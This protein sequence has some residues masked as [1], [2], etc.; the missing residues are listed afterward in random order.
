MNNKFAICI[1]TYNRADLL[2]PAL[3]YYLTDFPT[4][5]IYVL[6]NSDDFGLHTKDTF[7]KLCFQLRLPVTNIIFLHEEVNIGV[8][9]SW[10]KLVNMAFDT[11]HSHVLMLNDD[12]YLG[13]KEHSFTNILLH[14][15]SNNFDVEFM[16][17]KELDFSSFLISKNLYKKIG[18]FDE[19]YYPAYYEDADYK[20][21]MASKGLFVNNFN[22]YLMDCMVI[23]KSSSLQKEP[24][25]LDG[26]KEK[27]KARFLEKWGQYSEEFK[28][29]KISV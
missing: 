11:G 19:A 27:N 29:L 2:I 21:R 12:V 26:Y 22:Y 25:L 10:N 5:K 23:N 1:P 3:L 6:V 9:A 15:Q 8:A 4:T 16:T 14:F 7:I 20:M 18:A 24:T 17:N 28:L 13:Q